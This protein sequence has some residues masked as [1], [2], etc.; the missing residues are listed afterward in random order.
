MEEELEEQEH[1][2]EQEQEQE[3]QEEE[4]EEHEATAR[5]CKTRTMQR[6]SSRRRESPFGC[7]RPIDSEIF[8]IHAVRDRKDG[9]PD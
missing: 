9:H 3:Q 7:D 2:Q 6:A 8:Q 4:E 1:E 5:R